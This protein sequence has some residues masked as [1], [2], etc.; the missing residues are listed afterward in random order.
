MGAEDICCAVTQ[1]LNILD[2]IGNIVRDFA[3]ALAFRQQQVLADPRGE[4]ER[5][6]F[7]EHGRGLPYAMLRIAVREAYATEYHWCLSQKTS[8]VALP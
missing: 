3:F 1:V 4:L 6:L 7:A 2:Q 5:Q 8:V